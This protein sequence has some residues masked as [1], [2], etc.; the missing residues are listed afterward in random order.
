MEALPA[1]GRPLCLC[2]CQAAAGAET[3]AFSLRPIRR[4]ALVDLLRLV[5]AVLARD[6]AL[7]ELE[8]ARVE[9][10][11]AVD[12]DLHDVQQL[13][14][15]DATHAPACLRQRREPVTAARP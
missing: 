12:P 8:I 11:C 6:Q 2:S 14:E 7:H 3:G 13:R 1:R 4:Q 5:E 15:L 10:H 9:P